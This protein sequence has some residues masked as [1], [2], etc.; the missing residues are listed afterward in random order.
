MIYFLLFIGLLA[1]GIPIALVLG[2]T[3]FVH[4][5]TVNPDVLSIMPQRMLSV[6]NNFTLLAI[7][8]FVLAGELM[9]SSGITAKLVNFSR[10]IIGHMRGALGYVTVLVSLF[11][12][13]ILGSA[14]AEAAI[15]SSTLVPQ[16]E[17][18]GYKRE[19]AAAITASCSTLGPIFP[20]SISFII[21]A[22]LAN[23]SIGAMFIAG[24]IPA[25]VIA[26]AHMVYIYFYARK[27]QLNKHPLPSFKQFLKSFLDAAP[28]LLVPV[29]ILGGIFSGF[30]TATQ[31][32]AIACLVAIIIGFLSKNI[33][34]SDLPKILFKASITTASISII[35][36]TSNILGW[37]LASEQVP[38]QATS[39]F[40]AISDNP[41]IILLLVN[42]LLLLVGM[43]LD[44]TAALLILTPV[45]IP[46]ITTLG[47]DPIHFGVLVCFNLT[48]GLCTPPV[49]T[50][51]FITS[52]ITK[53]SL[54]R[55]VAAM[56]P[57]F[58]VLIIA[59]L[60]ITFIPQVCLTLP[61]LF[62]M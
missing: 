37:S 20:P 17:K 42:I 46:V 10:N 9:N 52:N 40:L 4:I 7:P 21:Y 3:G 11:L 13:A 35:V 56:L 55:L 41:L 18:D 45:L 8:F 23:V 59:L 34:L 44:I 27:R 12:G 30:F 38:Q 58:A 49:G 28:A 2:I 24:I 5:L 32:G 50:V 29:I 39:V 36:A 26:F 6:I 14:A 25:L 57:L 53:V 22:V 43:F 48:I 16:M 62:G 51:L 61:K 19:A 47:I 31:S 33:K 1:A 54:H 60:I 15:C